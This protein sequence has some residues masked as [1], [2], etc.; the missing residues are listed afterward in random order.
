M[1]HITRYVL[2]IEYNGAS[3]CGWQRQLSPA[4]PTVQG[5]L[6]QALAYVANAPVS[7]SCAG[8]TDAG[9]HGSGQVVHF[10][11]PS[12]RHEKAWVMGTNTRLP[13][14]VRVQWARVVPE[15]FHARHS[16]LSRRYRYVIYCGKVKPAV[17]IGQL[18]HVPESLDVQLMHQA[19]QSLVGEHDFSTFRA[20]GCQANTPM[21]EVKF[22]EVRRQGQFVVLEIE[23]NAFLQH[24][25]RN[26]TGSL[27]QVAMGRQPVQWI[28]EVLAG[29]DR[30]LAGVTARPD[31]LYLVGVEYP[32][33]FGLPV[34]PYGPCFL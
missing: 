1:S 11:C 16:A 18:T 24:M 23:A 9:V 5:V 3:F 7:I 33:R 22:V 30:S 10:D 8:R 26:I 2:G 17:L 25:V 29:R 32:S 4:L 13:P 15:D 28:A 6:E 14:E 19:A 27:L 34:L 20:A 21:R 12:I 31:G